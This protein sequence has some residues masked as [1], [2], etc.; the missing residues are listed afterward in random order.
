MTLWPYQS[1]WHGN[2]HFYLPYNQCYKAGH[3]KR[4]PRAN[5]HGSTTRVSAGCHSHCS[6]HWGKWG[7]VWLPFL[8]HTNK[9]SWTKIC[10]SSPPYCHCY[11]HHN[12][13]LAFAWFSKLWACLARTRLATSI[14]PQWANQTHSV[15]AHG[16][17]LNQKKQHINLLLTSF[18]ILLMN[19]A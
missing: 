7:T 4:Q 15:S 2:V 5:I 3:W 8:N 11:L 1:P 16:Y 14:G 12:A 17:T 13:A 19:E 18:F 6:C 10:N 9:C